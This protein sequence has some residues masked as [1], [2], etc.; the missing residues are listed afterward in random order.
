VAVASGSEYVLWD[1]ATGERLAQVGTDGSASSEFALDAGGGLLVARVSLGPDRREWRFLDTATGKPKPG[2]SG[3][4]GGWTFAFAP[5]RKTLL[6]GDRD[7]VQVWDPVAGKAVRTFAG[8]ACGYYGQQKTPPQLSPDGKLVVAH[9]GHGLL[10][11]DSTTGKPLFPEQNV[12]HGE[13]VSAVGVSPDGSRV[14]TYGFD[15]RVCLWDAATGKRL[16]KAPVGGE[17]VTSVPFSPDGRFVFAGGP[18]WGEVTKLDAATG[19]AVRVFAVDPK[20][21]KQGSFSS[22]RVS[23]DGK[24]LYGLSSGL[25]LNNAGC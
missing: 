18:K 25:G 24:T 13:A 19:E 23:A 6:V 4:A 10:R 17:H 2:L 15:Y 8:T 5:D 16:W 11:W 12:G 14:A 7:G 9:N 1:A 3:P 22:F 20:G 21:P